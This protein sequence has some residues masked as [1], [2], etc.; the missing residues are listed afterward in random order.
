[1]LYETHKNSYTGPRLNTLFDL[2]KYL[3]IFISFGCAYRQYDPEHCALNVVRSH[4]IQISGWIS[5][6]SISE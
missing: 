4:D 6:S 2:I 5:L 3:A 1:M